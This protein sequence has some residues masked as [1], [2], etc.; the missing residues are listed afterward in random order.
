MITVATT[1]DVPIKLTFESGSK[2]SMLGLGDIVIP[3]MVICLALRFD[4]WLHYHRQLRHT[5]VELVSETMD[6]E[7]KVTLIKKDTKHM[8]TKPRYI[9]ITGS[10]AD[11][12]WTSEWQTMLSRPRAPA[13]VAAASFNKTYFTAAMF[14]YALG[15]IA[16]L[17]ALLVFHHGQPALLY[18]VPGVLGSL[19]L[20]GLARG[21]IHEMWIYTEDGSLDSEDVVVEIEMDKDGRMI[22]VEGG[23]KP[24]PVGKDAQGARNALASR[25]DPLE[26]G[27]EETDQNKEVT[28]K[29]KRARDRYILLFSVAAPRGDS[30]SDSE[31]Q[32]EGGDDAKDDTKE[33]EE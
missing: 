6:P 24:A 16:T 4:H 10:W 9:D 15:M 2:S 13:S 30:E 25:T 26:K 18:L 19:W 3:G 27:L 12:F 5:P 28:R 1:L 31:S 14:G 23:A 7:T 20:T 32:S 29:R 33:H 11:W 21:E 17:A 8:A 22:K